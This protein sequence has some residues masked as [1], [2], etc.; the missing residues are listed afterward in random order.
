M[1]ISKIP[2]MCRNSNK[3]SKKE[4]EYICIIYQGLKS[5]AGKED[6][7]QKQVTATAQLLAF[8]KAQFIL[9]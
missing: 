8:D 5:M 7:L 6:N 1:G 2:G 3:E 4:K 9:F